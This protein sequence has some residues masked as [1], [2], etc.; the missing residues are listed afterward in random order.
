LEI[1]DWRLEIGDW[2]LE[3]GDFLAGVATACFRSWRVEFV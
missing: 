2:R 1:G 3:I